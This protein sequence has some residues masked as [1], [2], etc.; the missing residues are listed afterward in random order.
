MVRNLNIM[1]YKHI[2]SLFFFQAPMMVKAQ[3]ELADVFLNNIGNRKEYIKCFQR[4]LKKSKTTN[5]ILLLCNAYMKTNSP[6]KAV[7]VLRTAN[8][9]NPKNEKI[10]EY[11]GK[12]LRMMGDP[13]GALECYEDDIRNHPWHQSIRVE[14]IKIYIDLN[15]HDKA[16][17]LLNRSINDFDNIEVA[18]SDILATKFSLLLMLAEVHEAS[19][20]MDRMR[21]VILSAKEIICNKAV[22]CESMFAEGSDNRKKLSDLFCRIADNCE[23]KED[24]LGAEEMI[25]DALDIQC[26][27]ESILLRLGKVYLSQNEFEQCF[28]ITTKLASSS[29]GALQLRGDLLIAQSH[30]DDACSVYM[31]LLALNPVNYIVVETCLSLLY[32]LG[33]ADEVQQLIYKAESLDNDPS[34]PGLL[35]SKVSMG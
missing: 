13:D 16:T 34:S 17:I 26:D 19:N 4:I 8:S 35:F 23:G 11:L 21:E 3:I 7:E 32:R 15:L 33:R 5:N 31:K 6:S 9:E 29:E 25:K 2:R 30:L 12:A 18:T 24:F 14:L 22:C 10:T 1:F 28:N 27:D 20:H